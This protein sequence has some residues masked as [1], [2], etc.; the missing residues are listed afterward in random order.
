MRLR[1]TLV[2]AL[3]VVVAPAL[4]G[5]SVAENIVGGVV[6]EAQNQAGDAISE[7]LGGAG[8]TTDGELPS[9]FPA[10]AIPVVGT[11]QGGGAAPDGAGWVVIST[12]GADE[13]FAAAQA[14]LE[15]AG[16]VSSAVNSDADSGF[17]N[18]ALAPYGVVLT[19][20]T[21]TDDVTTATYVVSA[22]TE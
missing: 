13:D 1:S 2:I 19:V 9:G 3:T 20:A 8:V 14:A 21:D 6:S 22:T 7:A 15:G 4:V 10:D 5:C 18:F 17:G 11:V 16:F 12:L